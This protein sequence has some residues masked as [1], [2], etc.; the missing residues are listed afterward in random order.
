MQSASKS[1]LTRPTASTTVQLLLLRIP[2]LLEK[3]SLVAMD[4]AAKYAESRR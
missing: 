2:S 4:V 3:Q 1:V